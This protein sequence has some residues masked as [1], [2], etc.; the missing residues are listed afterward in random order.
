M[1]P[2]CGC[3]VVCGQLVFKDAAKAWRI[4]MA[5]T[6][7]SSSVVARE[8]FTGLRHSAVVPPPARGAGPMAVTLAPT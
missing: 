3:G 2:V 6:A 1:G 8:V 4:G 7:A 5:K